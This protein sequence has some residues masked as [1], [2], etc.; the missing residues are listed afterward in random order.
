[1]FGVA[2]G[3]DGCLIITSIG[4][5]SVSAGG[6][7]FDDFGVTDGAVN[8]IGDGSAGAFIIRGYAGMA[9]RTTGRLMGRGMGFERI[10][11]EGDFDAIAGHS[12][13]WI[14]VA[15]EAI[16]VGDLAV[17]DFANIVRF[18]AIDADRNLVRL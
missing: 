8:P 3:T 5:D 10:N 17:K 6:V 7:G 9:L 18:M 4:Q 11:G 13:V 2:I 16:G 12:Q 1:M 14:G 15:F